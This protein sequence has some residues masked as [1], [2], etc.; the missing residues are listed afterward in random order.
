MAAAAVGGNQRARA[1]EEELA[2]L[3][4]T[5]PRLPPA[6]RIAVRTVLDALLAEGALDDRD[7][8]AAESLRD[9]LG[10]E[11]PLVLVA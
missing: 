9:A 10:A 6:A 1:W 7:A 2:E 4:K 11:R 3:A 8:R 5:L